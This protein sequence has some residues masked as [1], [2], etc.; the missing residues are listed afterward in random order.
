[1]ENKTSKERT[2]AY[3]NASLISKEDMEKICGGNQQLFPTLGG[4]LNPYGVDARIDA[5]W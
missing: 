2:L 1:M 3:Q 4:T 5:H